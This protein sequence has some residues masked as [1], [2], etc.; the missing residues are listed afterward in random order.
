MFIA[1]HF[2]QPAVCLLERAASFCFGGFLFLLTQ[3]SPNEY[4]VNTTTSGRRQYDVRHVAVID[5]GTTSYRR[6]LLIGPTAGRRRA[7]AARRRHDLG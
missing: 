4:P 7:D 6:R 5:V 2:Q 1:V 3:L